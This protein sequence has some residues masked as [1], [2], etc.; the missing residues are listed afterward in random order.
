MTLSCKD[1]LKNY[2]KHNYKKIPRK[3]AFKGVSIKDIYNITAPFIDNGIET[4]AGRVESRN[5]ELSKVMFFQKCDENWIHVIDSPIFNLQDPFFTKIKDELIIGG[6]EIYPDNTTTND[7]LY[8]W[9]TVMYRGRDIF[10]LKLFFIGPD[11]MKDLRIVELNSGEI[12]IFSRP[13]G[14]KGGKGKIGFTKVDTL[15]NLSI[16][17]INNASILKDLFD[18]S[19]WGGTNA[20]YPLFDDY[21]GVLGHIACFD[22]NKNRH[23][24]SMSFIFDTKTYKY[25]DV[26]ILAERSDFLPGE[27]KRPDLSDVIFSG[28]M[29]LNDKKASLY[30]GVSD[31]ESQIMEIDNPFIDFMKENNKKG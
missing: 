13:Q 31:T 17:I 29:V 5:S 7:K 1:L 22:E 18:D 10:N 28:G 30:T 2:R 16:G 6:V 21:V 9:R 20:V 15:D 11:G 26:K 4:L 24:Y 12:G 23:Y 14:I 8:S 25:S 3:L 19:E 27:S